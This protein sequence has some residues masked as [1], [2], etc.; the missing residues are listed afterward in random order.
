MVDESDGWQGS[1][2][3]TKRWFLAERFQVAVVKLT[4]NIVSDYVKTVNQ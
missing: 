3:E 1:A 4:G 2:A